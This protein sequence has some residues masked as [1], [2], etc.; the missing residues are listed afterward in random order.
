[1]GG[2]RQAVARRPDLW[3]EVA[4]SS[5]AFAPIGWWRR[6]PFLPLPERRYLEW[7][8]FTAYGTT[9]RALSGD[10]VVAFLEWRR[11]LRKSL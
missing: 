4:R 6:F 5:V 2:V 7:R 10:D 11:R 1:V 3:T 8:R 9:D